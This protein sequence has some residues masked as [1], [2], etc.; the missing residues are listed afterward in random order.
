M[1]GLKI[2]RTLY[3]P[4]TKDKK[5]FPKLKSIKNSLHLKKIS[6]ENFND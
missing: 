1:I 2:N 6:Q 5:T 4:F 3:V